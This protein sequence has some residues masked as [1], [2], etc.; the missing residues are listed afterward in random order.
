MK[1]R[2]AIVIAVFALVLLPTSC[3][4]LSGR[5]ESLADYSA[6]ISI[7]RENRNLLRELSIPEVIRDTTVIED[8]KGNLYHL[9]RAVRDDKSGEMVATEELNAAVVTARFR[10]VAERNGKVD[11]EFQV[12]VPKELRD[13]KWQLRMIPV[14]YILEDSVELDRILI[15]GES[16]R[17]SQLRGYQQY[18]RFLNSIITDSTR[19]V[20]MH[21][22]E[23]FIQRNIPELYKYRTDSAYVSDEL[24]MSHY[25]ITEKEALEHYTYGLRLRR[26]EWKKNNIGKMYDRYVKAP[27]V[28]EHLRLDTVM[29][30]R[31]GDFIYNYVQRVRTRP[32]LRKVEIVLGGEIYEQENKIY[33]IE[34]SDPLTF[35]ISSL[36]AFAEERE[37]YLT[38][39]VSRRVKADAVCR[40]EFEKDRDEV[41]EGLSMNYQEIARIRQTLRLL[42]ENKDF[43]PD[44]IVVTASSSPEG[45]W[46]YN[47][48]LSKRRSASVSRYFERFIK[49]WRDSSASERGLA[50]DMEKGAIKRGREEPKSS[51]EFISRSIAED[52][53][54]LDRLVMADTVMTPFQKERYFLLAGEKD[55][56]K[57]ERLLS[58]EDLYQHLI[59]ELYPKLRTVRF[60]FHLH[61]KDMVR[62][63]IHTTII[64][65][66]YMAGVQALQNR[67]YKMAVTLLAPYRDFN[68]AVAYCAADYNASALDLL[69]ELPPTPK[70]SYL[71]ALLK[72]REGDNKS[73][74][75]HYLSAC[76]QDSHYIHRGNLDPEIYSLIQMYDLNRYFE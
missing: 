44:S 43:D 71:M 60:E 57:R 64:D 53:S 68:T 20:D 74:V 4:T 52:W 63:T 27:I 69:S 40:I 46:E 25:G 13:S 36:S 70:V 37:R 7:P 33:T 56:D 51:F 19:F 29:C 55:P 21:Q 31:S 24:F 59:C 62:D 5:M 15:T 58:M 48:R 22:L 42:L 18:R 10:N 6:S 41:L 49:S 12:V 50:I 32:H 30:N 9:M 23:V 8:E 2:I 38:Q 66:T 28:T 3:G 35:Y 1:N 67:D 11:I 16:Y 75:E 47:S 76:R 17:K 34:P 65:S 14:M 72:M 73:A 39:V 61:R 26:N 54:A 45:T